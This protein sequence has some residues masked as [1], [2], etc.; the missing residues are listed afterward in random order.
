MILGLDI[1]TSIT[2]YTIIDLDGSVVVCDHIDLKKYNN[3]YDKVNKVREVLREIFE[4]HF[5]DKVFIE[6]SLMMFSAGL[7]SAKV[8]N[9]LSKFNGIVSWILK[10]EF[11]KEPFYIPASSA[12][13][14][15]GL[16]M[17]KGRKGK[18]IVMDYMRDEQKWFVIEYT[19]NNKI[20]PFCFDRA[21]SFVIARAGFLSK[22]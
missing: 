3:I 22:P 2:G 5:I 13:K 12:R 14:Q 10:D 9:L 21:D 20:K 15:I 8:L 16:K 17:V 19:K 6:E 7:S 1:S 11:K 4:K 18:E